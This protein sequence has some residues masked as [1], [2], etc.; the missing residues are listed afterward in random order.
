MKLLEP[1]SKWS[2]RFTNVV[3][4]I[5]TPRYN[6]SVNHPTLLCGSNSVFGSYQEVSDGSTSFTL[7]CTNIACLIQIF[8][9]DFTEAFCIWHYHATIIILC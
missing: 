7:Q 3:L 9:K 6:L 4:N 8:F 5:L 1:L 2:C